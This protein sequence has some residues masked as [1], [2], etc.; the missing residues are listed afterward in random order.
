MKLL[1]STE[2]KITKNKNEE[3]VTHLET[4]EVILIY[5]NVVNNIYQ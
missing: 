4:T 5:C 1:R 3:N 2:N